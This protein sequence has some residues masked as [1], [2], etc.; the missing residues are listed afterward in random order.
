MLGQIGINVDLI[1]APTQAGG[2]SFANG[3][4]D[5]TWIQLISID[6]GDT[7]ANVYLNSTPPVTPLIPVADQ[8]QFLPLQEKLT[9]PNATQ[10]ERAKVWATDRD[11]AL[12]QRVR[13]AGVQR[14]TGVAAGRVDRE[15]GRPAQRVERVDRLQVPVQ[16]EVISHAAIHREAALPQQRRGVVHLGENLNTD[17]GTVSAIATGKI[18]LDFEAA[19]APGG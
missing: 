13:R 10:A 19:K 12:R 3:D 8:A 17:G 5:L 4:F 11:Q 18:V 16:A 2:P 14:F 6:P 9:D 7:L 15:H 1:P